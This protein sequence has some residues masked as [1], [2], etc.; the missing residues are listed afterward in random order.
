MDTVEANFKIEVHNYAAIDFFAFVDAIDA[1]GGVSVEVEENDLW[2]L[3]GLVT[4]AGEQVLMGEQALAFARNRKF[5]SADFIRTENQRHMLS[6]LFAKMKDADLATIDAA[7]DAILPGITTD[8]SELQ[9]ISWI[10]LAPK[11]LGY[12]LAT[13]RLP[14][15]D[16]YS[17]ISLNGASMLSLDFDK[18]V[19]YLYDIIHDEVTE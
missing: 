8:M 17:H 6:R 14:I 3:N 16:S 13:Y 1:I 12:E 10:T 15:D 18:N 19:E 7:L 9:L 4:E 2:G 5:P 11:L